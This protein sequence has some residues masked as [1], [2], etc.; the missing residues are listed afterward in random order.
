VRDAKRA[1]DDDGMR[2]RRRRAASGGT[3][4]AEGARNALVWQAASRLPPEAERSRARPSGR[5]RLARRRTCARRV[6]TKTNSLSALATPTAAARQVQ[7]G[8]NRLGLLELQCAH[9][10]AA[11]FTEINSSKQ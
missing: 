8:A 11:E 4:R 7:E 9:A 2:R 3:R 1:R 10:V 5:L 6:G